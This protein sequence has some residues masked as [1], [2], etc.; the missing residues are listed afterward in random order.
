[1]RSSADAWKCAVAGAGLFAGLAGLLGACSPPG[2]TAAE[3]QERGAALYAQ[4]CA[5]C[6][7]VEGGIGPRLKPGVL[8][9]YASAQTL[10]NYLRIAMPT[11]APG[12]LPEDEY[13]AIIAFLLEDRGLIAGDEVLDAARAPSVALKETPE[14]T[15]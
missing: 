13:W 5:A 15:N 2:P 9:G 11:Q 8:A 1:M 3:Q 12:S 4:Q 6:H 7:E 14:P 10:Y